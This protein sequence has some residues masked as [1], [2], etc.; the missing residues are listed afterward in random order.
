MIVAQSSPTLVEKENIVGLH[1]PKGDVL[2]EPSEKKERL[3]KLRR[4]T[5]LGNIEHSKIRIYF[6]DD[7]GPK[8]VHTTIWATTDDAVVLKRGVVIPMDRIHRVE[9]L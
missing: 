8:V 5:F 3:L 9:L 2:S 7:T 6:S 1:F 4:A